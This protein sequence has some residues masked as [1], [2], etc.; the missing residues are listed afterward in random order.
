MEQDELRWRQYQL[1]VDLYKF[2]LELVLKLNAGY[3]L[4]TTWLRAP[5]SPTI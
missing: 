5:S 4:V 2:Y 3:Y 1:H